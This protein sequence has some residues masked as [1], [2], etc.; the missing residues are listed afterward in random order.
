MIAP[1]AACYMGLM[2]TQNYMATD[3]EFR[4]KVC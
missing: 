1:C 2:K 4:E 3:P